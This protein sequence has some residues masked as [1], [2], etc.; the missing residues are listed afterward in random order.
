MSKFLP[1]SVRILIEELSRL[2]GIGPKSAQ[3]LAIYLLRSPNTRLQPLG[4]SILKLRENVVFCGECW[5][6]AENDPCVI[7]DDDQ[8][9]KEIICV[10]E[11]FLDVV[12]IEKTRDFKGLYH[13][14]HGALSPVDGVGP[15]QLKIEALFKRI[16]KGDDIS[17]VI[18]AT[19]PSLEGEATAL[20]I[21]KNLMELGEKVNVTRIARGLPVGGDL[22]YADEITLSRALKG[23]GSF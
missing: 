20:Y 17:E 14:L 22:E 16:R 5:N 3:R 15:E 13:V 7:C 8:R 12:A 21:Q 4:E 19:N 18:L 9:D 11:E 10:V 23:R 6:I 1:K 2:P